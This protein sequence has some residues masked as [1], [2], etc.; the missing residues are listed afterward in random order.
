M[1]G[2]LVHRPT[3][4]CSV[5]RWVPAEAGFCNTYAE[6]PVGPE[7]TDG[8]RMARSSIPPAPFLGD[9]IDDSTDNSHGYARR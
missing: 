4:H 6:R 2:V 7:P 5:N 8:G 1:K 3:V 9:V